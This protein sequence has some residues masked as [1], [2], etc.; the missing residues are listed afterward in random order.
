VIHRTG[1]RFRDVCSRRLLPLITTEVIQMMEEE[2]G[3]ELTE[4][5]KNRYIAQAKL[6]EDRTFK[7][8]VS[9]AQ[10]D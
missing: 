3:E 5:E 10:K 1:P 9:G 7:K 2:K 4:Q 6:I 8:R